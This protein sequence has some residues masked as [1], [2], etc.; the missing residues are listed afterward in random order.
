MSCTA[1]SPRPSTNADIKVN[2]MRVPSL[3][4]KAMEDIRYI[5]HPVLKHHIMPNRPII[6]PNI[7]EH[8][9]SCTAH[10]HAF[11][12]SIFLLLFVHIHTQKANK[13]TKPIFPCFS[14]HY[15]NFPCS[16][17]ILFSLR[18]EYSQQQVSSSKLGKL[19]Y[20]KFTKGKGNKDLKHLVDFSLPQISS[21]FILII[22]KQQKDVINVKHNS[23]LLLWG[24]KIKTR[25]PDVEAMYTQKHKKTF[26]RTIF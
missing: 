25:N 8:P 3:S 10:C 5:V 11:R 21:L 4:G 23:F 19:N 14:S 17:L 15:W 26:I 6:P 9:I 12:Q 20:W 7:T 2:T 13:Q 22:I 24:T 1:L 18:Y 16:S